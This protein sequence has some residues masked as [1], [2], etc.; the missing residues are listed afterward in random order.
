[1]NWR[2]VSLPAARAVSSP[3]IWDWKGLDSTH[4][5]AARGLK[6]RQIS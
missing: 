5:D 1:M 2:P 4:D 3:S 6:N